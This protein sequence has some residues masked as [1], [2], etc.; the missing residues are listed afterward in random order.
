[1]TPSLAP[2]RTAPVARQKVWAGGRLSTLGFGAGLPPSTGELWLVSDLAVAPSPIASGPHAGADLRQL[3]AAQPEALLGECFAGP[4][5]AAS[6][7]LLVKILDIGAPLSVQVH[8]DACVARAL[9]DGDRGKCE[10]WLVLE[11]APGGAALVG[12]RAG[13]SPDAVPSLAAAGTLADALERLEPE[14]GEGIEIAPGT[15]HTA[16][17]LVVL[18]VQE[19]SDVTYRVY[20]Y[21]RRRGPLH[22]AQAARCL[23]QAPAP[24]ARTGAWAPGARE[25]APRAPF[26]FRA[27]ELRAGESLSPPEGAVPRV[28]VVLSGRVAVGPLE[29][30]PGEVAVLPATWRGADDGQARVNSR[31]GHA[32]PR[33]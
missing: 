17:G 29:L 9:G 32:F 12:L 10:A 21:G 31:L 7:P 20:D 11:R 25:L 26:S 28:L 24:P 15:L 33:A 3:V 16:E 2:F 1:M 5:E 22:L 6:F 30:G 23:E 18:E 19:P 13:V 14:P 4:D 27:V 8:P